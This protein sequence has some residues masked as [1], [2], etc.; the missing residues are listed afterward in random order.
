MV[1]ALICPYCGSSTQAGYL[2]GSRGYALLWTT[3]PFKATSLPL[4]DDFLLCRETDLEKP[5]AFLCR[6]CGKIIIDINE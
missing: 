1:N 5:L 3:D 2:R 4:G 6:S